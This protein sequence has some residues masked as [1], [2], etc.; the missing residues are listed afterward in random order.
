MEERAYAF[1]GCLI[2][3][4]LLFLADQAEFYSHS[5]LSQI[6]FWFF[7]TFFGLMSIVC[8]V[9]SLLPNNKS[10]KVKGKKKPR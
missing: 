6:I 7:K 3:L 10:K 4:V 2:L 8:F 5:C 1:V 9:H